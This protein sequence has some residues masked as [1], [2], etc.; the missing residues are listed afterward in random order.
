MI[1]LTFSV[2]LQ[3]ASFI[4]G[5]CVCGGWGGDCTGL[6]EDWYQNIFVVA[7]TTYQYGNSLISQQSW[8]GSD[9]AV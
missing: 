2:L 6:T 8:G 9:L 7:G 4:P 1:E 5:V 3:M